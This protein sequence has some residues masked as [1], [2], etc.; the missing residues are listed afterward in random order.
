MPPSRR[1]PLLENGPMGRKNAKPEAQDAPPTAT[2]PEAVPVPEPSANGSHANGAPANGTPDDT[3]NRPVK[4]FSCPAGGGVYIEASIWPK[5]I[6][7]EDKA[8][9]V[10]NV[11]SRKSYKKDDGSYGNTQF[12]RGSEIPIVVHVL[13]LAARFIL[14][15]RTDE[16]PPF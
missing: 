5:E 8:V 4:T 1:N 6:T 9:T 11:T 16:E 2:V 12:F 15:Q 14:N 3:K 13:E 7:I 10:Y